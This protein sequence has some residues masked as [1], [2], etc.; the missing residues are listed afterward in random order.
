MFRLTRANTLR[1]R[2]RTASGGFADVATLRVESDRG[3]QLFA[4]SRDQAEL[5]IALGCCKTSNG[6][7]S[8]GSSRDHLSGVENPNHGEFVL[9]SLEPNLPLTIEVVAADETSLL[10]QRLVTPPIGEELTVDLVVMASTRRVSGTVCSLEGKALRAQVQLDTASDRRVYGEAPDGKF[11]LPG[12]Y[13]QPRTIT[14]TANGYAAQK[15]DLLTTVVD[16]SDLR[17]K[18]EPGRQITLRV[19]EQSGSLVPLVKGEYD[20]SLLLN[21]I[22]R[23]TTLRPGEIV[24]SDLPSGFAVFA[25]T[26]G[27][28]H[29]SLRHDTE[30]PEAT[31]RVPNLGRIFVSAP[32]DVPDDDGPLYG[33]AV[34]ID[35]P[36]TAEFLISSD[37]AT[38]NSGLVP[39]GRYRVVLARS[40][41]TNELGPAVDVVVQ[42]G[43]TAEV[44]LH[45]SKEI[46]K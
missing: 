25:C 36:G 20:E 46:H 3:S 22:A 28:Q 37:E 23:E 40:L 1:L 18:L 7:I 42:P 24:Y 8:R 32:A 12:I 14:V 13:S 16:T 2:P 44:Q 15:M 34:R 17:F 10:I 35:M 27:G 19:L 38:S 11:S 5:D 4:G 9:H 39:A 6:T 41:K 30:Q 29:F 26:L 33:K 21:G 31:L 43:Q 45:W